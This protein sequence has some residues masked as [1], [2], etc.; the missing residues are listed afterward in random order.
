[1]TTNQQIPAEQ[2]AETVAEQ[3][4][5][6][7]QNRAQAEEPRRQLRSDIAAL[8][9]KIHAH[10]CD[11]RS[12]L[13]RLRRHAVVFRAG[14]LSGRAKGTNYRSEQPICRGSRCHGQRE[15]MLQQSACAALDV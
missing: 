12:L 8:D 5:K 9:E 15:R 1:M 4:R 2:R 3:A 10:E 13:S 7:H 6:L 11:R 14:K